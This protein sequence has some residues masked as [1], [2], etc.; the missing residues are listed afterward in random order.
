MF[1]KKSTNDESYKTDDSL[2]ARKGQL[3]LSA[4]ALK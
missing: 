3:L 1:E 2:N 4:M